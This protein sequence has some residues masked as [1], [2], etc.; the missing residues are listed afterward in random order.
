MAS[1]IELSRKAHPQRAPSLPPLSTS[2]HPSLLGRSAA[3]RPAT[4]AFS[5]I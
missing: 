2:L 4:A 1:L 5:G 3:R